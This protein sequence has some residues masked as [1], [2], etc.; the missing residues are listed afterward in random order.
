MRYIDV[1][2]SQ[3]VA[4]IADRTVSQQTIYKL[5]IIAKLH[6]QLFSR[7]CTVSMTEFDLSRSHDVKDHVTVW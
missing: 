4:R 6:L 2:R 1:S 5:A 7:Y 3:A